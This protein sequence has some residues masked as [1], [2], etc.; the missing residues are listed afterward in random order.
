MSKSSRRLAAGLVGITAFC[1]IAT[2]FAILP[3]APWR[4]DRADTGRILKVQQRGGGRMSRE[5][6]EKMMKERFDNMCQ[7]LKLDDK[8]KK[9][10]QK[11][12]E[13]RNKE[14]AQIFSD[15]RDGKIEREEARKRMEESM[16]KYQEGL[17]KILTAQQK[18]QLKTWIEQNPERRP[19]R[20]GGGGAALID[21][22][23]LSDTQVA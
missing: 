13:A 23:G 21:R 15:S 20:P 17:E 16:K 12:F 10:A 4:A 14:T 9:E 11:L 22:F 6:R 5:E 8:Q 18:E 2:G 1:L 19:G 7:F 3:A